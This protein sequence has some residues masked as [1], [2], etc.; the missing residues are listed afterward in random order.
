MNKKLLIVSLSLLMFN[1]QTKSKTNPA[2]LDTTFGPNMNG[3][4]TFQFPGST[5]DHGEG[6]IVLDD[7]GRIIVSGSNIINETIIVVRF[8]PNGTVDTTFGDNGATSVAL[9]PLGRGSGGVVRDTQGNII[10]AGYKSSPNEYVVSRLLEDGTPDP[11]FGTN[12]VIIGTSNNI[13]NITGIK[14]NREGKIVLYGNII[15]STTAVIQLNTDG[16]LDTAFGTGGFAFINAPLNDRSDSDFIID[17]QGRIIVSSDSG[18]DFVVARINPDGLLDTTFGVDGISVIDTPE[19]DFGEGGV[20]LTRD[21]KIVVLGT[22]FT[23]DN[24]TIFQLDSNGILDLS[25][26]T[27]GFVKI[28][29]SM[30]GDGG[31]TIDSWGNIYAY[32]SFIDADYSKRRF[33]LARL[34]PQG[35]LDSTFGNNGLALYGPFLIADT[36]HGG[37]IIIDAQGRVLLLG[38]ETTGASTSSFAITRSCGDQSPEL[39]TALREKYR[40]NCSVLPGC[41]GTP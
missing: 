13:G 20:A 24:M 34:T 5:R 31:I 29:P 17:C 25:F 18:N 8:L 22:D 23:G 15:G 41:A 14:L 19:S 3:L 32:G 21:G 40:A 16:S 35:S 10:V 27:N 30:Q 33:V 39:T 11:S 26:G 37:G 1:Q 2:D 38:S 28:G 9:G 36:A 4:V 12:G 7:Q 6:G